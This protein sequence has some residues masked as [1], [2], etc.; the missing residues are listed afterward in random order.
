[1]P[2]EEKQRKVYQSKL[3]GYARD[4]LMNLDSVLKKNVLKCTIQSLIFQC[5]KNEDEDT[6]LD[7]ARVVTLQ[8]TYVFI[9]Q[10]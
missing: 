8:D 3:F 2:K 1:M 6:K 4:V 10:I 5:K 7:D 9:G